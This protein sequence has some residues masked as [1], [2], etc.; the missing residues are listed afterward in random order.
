MLRAAT[1]WAFREIRRKAAR[2]ADKQRIHTLE[3][4][5]KQL[6]SE[7]ARWIWWYWRHPEFAECEAKE[8]A[9]REEKEELSQLQGQQQPFVMQQQQHQPRSIPIDYSRWDHLCTSDEEEEEE[10]GE[11]ENPEDSEEEVGEEEEDEHELEACWYAERQEEEGYDSEDDHGDEDNDE[12]D[13]DDRDEEEREEA[14]SVTDFTTVPA[15]NKVILVQHFS[16]AMQEVQGSFAEAERRLELM[17]VPLARAAEVFTPLMQQQR[18]QFTQYT[19]ML[20]S[21]EVHQFDEDG[22]RAVTSLLRR[23]VN[24]TQRQIQTLMGDDDSSK[25]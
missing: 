25:G 24:D 3:E 20:Q 11:K 23:L 16:Q 7:L 12:L 6:Q 13:A 4:E 15:Q 9:E 8:E 17:G 5:V 10:E 14:A 1:P 2:D 21:M 19:D 18:Q 22:S